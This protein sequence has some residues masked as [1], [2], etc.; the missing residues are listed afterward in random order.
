MQKSIDVHLSVAG[1]SQNR[2]K[3]KFM[4][5]DKIFTIISCS[6]SRGVSVAQF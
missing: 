5:V 1:Q 4:M 2:F 6:Q 3:L